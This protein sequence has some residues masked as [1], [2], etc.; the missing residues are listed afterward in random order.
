[1]RNETET[2]YYD[3]L[4]GK[5]AQTQWTKIVGPSGEGDLEALD[6][7]ARAYWYPL[8]WHARRKGYSEH[9]A[10]DLVQSFFARQL[11]S[12]GLKKADRNRGKFRTFLLTAFNNFVTSEWRRGKNIPDPIS[13]DELSETD[14]DEQLPQD[15][16][17]LDADFYR[18]WG[19][20]LLNLALQ[21]LE[22][23]QH[24]SGKGELFDHLKGHLAGANDLSSLSQIT[25]IPV[26]TLKSDLRRLRKFRLPELIEEEVRRTLCHP[27]DDEVSQEL[28]FIKL[29]AAGGTA[30]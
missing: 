5:F 18:D 11:A 8:Y 21:R 12:G 15:D 26:N 9:N 24:A 28:S 14:G 25:G 10:E 30:A 20:T 16:H 17:D 4:P 22:E 13:L 3:Q 6:L 7:L 2:P 27:T 1:M 29:H 23:E 19:L